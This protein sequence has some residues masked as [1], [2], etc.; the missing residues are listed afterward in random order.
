MQLTIH[1]GT[2]EIGGTCIEVSTS[3][4][5]MLLDVGLPLFD[6]NRQPLDSR[7]LRSLSTPALIRSG[8]L[9]SIPGLYDGKSPPAAILLSHAH[10]DHCGLLDRSFPEIPVYATTGTS[11]M[12]LA[13]SLFA[14]Q[15]RIPRERFHELRPKIPTRIGDFHVT[16]LAVDHSIFGAIAMLVEAEGQSLLYSG[17]LRLHGRKPQME[18]ILVE[19]IQEKNLDVL[20]MEG[21]LFGIPEIEKLNEYQL[22][23]QLVTHINEASGLVL[24]SF[25]PQHV[26]R[27][28]GLIRACLKSGRTFVADAYTAFVLRLIASETRVPVPGRDNDL[29]VFFPSSLWQDEAK[30]KM[31]AEKC[32]EFQAARIEMPQ[33]LARPQNYV[34]AFRGSM[35]D[36]DFGGTLPPGVV[37]LHSRWEGYLEKPDAQPW[38][39]ALERAHGKL[40]QLHTSGH[41]LPQDIVGFVNSLHPR[42]VIPV[43]T[44]VPEEF[45]ATLSNVRVLRDGEQV[46]LA[47]LSSSSY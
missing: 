2:R 36:G 46:D 30:R 16:P 39:Q 27:L 44:F 35:L 14:R 8:M 38:L 22:E 5:R 37:C 1:R 24:A 21:T 42:T 10:Q 11:K 40:V 29:P 19:T 28:V 23:D 41:I 12:M 15:I 4:S 3:N 6:S 32:P 31:L 17:D 7:P 18:K 20:L 13:G 25:S 26:D 45:A 43:H 47:E 33:I 34:M 9:P